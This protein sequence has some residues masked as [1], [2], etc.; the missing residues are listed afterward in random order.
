MKQKK[1]TLWQRFLDTLFP[2]R[3]VCCGELLPAGSPL[4]FCAICYANYQQS[5][6][7]VCRHCGRAIRDCVCCGETLLSA[8]VYR[9]SRVTA[10]L[11]ERRNSPENQLLYALKHK[12]L[13]IVRRFAASELASAIQRAPENT[14]GFFVTCVPRR[15]SS[16]REYGFD[17]AEELARRLSEELSLPFEAL[18]RRLPEAK[19]QKGLG[20][21]ERKKNAENSIRLR[22]GVSVSGK[23]YLIVDDVM[24][25]GASLAA[26]AAL[27]FSHGAT[28]VR[29]AVFASRG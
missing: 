27:L 18:F 3:C 19:E 2:P 1:M 22:D 23:R 24:T 21:E 11:P 5:R 17:H 10:Y 13:T 16:I 15:P 14:D 28:E 25:S 29:G 6:R 4:P 12:N 9:V 8:G 20:A 7:Y 26:C